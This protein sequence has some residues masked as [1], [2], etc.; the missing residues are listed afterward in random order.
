MRAAPT[1]TASSEA[2]RRI[3]GRPAA[4]DELEEWESFLERYQAAASLAGESPADAAA[5]PGRGSAAP[6][7]RPTICLRQLMKSTEIARELAR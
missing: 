7:C 5:W 4:A 2:C 6:S 1:A 3:L